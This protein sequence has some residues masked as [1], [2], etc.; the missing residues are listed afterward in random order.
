[1][2]RETNKRSI[3]KTIVF[4]IITTS[5]TAM[6]TGL[7]NALFIHALM[8]IIYLLHEWG[9]NKVNWGRI[10]LKKEN[11]ELLCNEQKGNL[12]HEKTYAQPVQS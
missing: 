2:Y 5:V 8:T 10:A 1:M 11:N 3:V 7:G 12:Q 6:I 9:W 4:K